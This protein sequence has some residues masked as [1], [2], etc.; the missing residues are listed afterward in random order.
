MSPFWYKLEADFG[1][2]NQMLSQ[3]HQCSKCSVVAMM[4]QSL[5][6]ILLTVL[7][8]AYCS[9]AQNEEATVTETDEESITLPDEGYQNGTNALDT[10]RAGRINA[11]TVADI[12]LYPY[13]ATLII[14]NATTTY[15]KTGVIISIKNVL[16]AALAVA[17]REPSVDSI[18]VRAG[19]NFVDQEGFTFETLPYQNHPQVNGPT[20]ANYAAVVTIKGNFIGYPKIQ[21]IELATSP[22]SSSAFC[23]ALG[24]GTNKSGTRVFKLS[25]ANYTPAT[26]ASCR[27]SYGS[28]SDKLI[29]FNSASGNLCTGDRGSPIV[30]NGLLH[31]LALTSVCNT[32]INPAIPI[33]D[34]VITPF[35]APFLVQPKPLFLCPCNTC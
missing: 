29:C 4:K 10:N 7:F 19:S 27:G 28:L 2:I 22:V 25:R 34:S 30:C 26:T 11:G 17:G 3:Y 13:V 24:W 6:V 18:V 9:K 16:T 12:S 23:L 21:P 14:T 5:K 15:Y 35:I 1:P 33:V 31:G 32:G 8:F 20:Y